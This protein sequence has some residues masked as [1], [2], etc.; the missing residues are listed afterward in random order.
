MAEKRTRAGN[1]GNVARELLG[2]VPVFPLEIELDVKRRGRCP[3]WDMGRV[4][5][6]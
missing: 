2:A 5:G 6:P 3:L 4:S 1:R